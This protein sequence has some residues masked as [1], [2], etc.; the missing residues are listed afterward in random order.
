MNRQAA[1]NIQRGQEDKAPD[2]EPTAQSAIL[3]SVNIVS[4]KRFRSDITLRHLR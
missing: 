1:K 4:D 2:G 3:R